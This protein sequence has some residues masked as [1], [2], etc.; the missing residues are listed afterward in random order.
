MHWRFSFTRMSPWNKETDSMTLK[1]LTVTTLGS[2]LK[3][4]LNNVLFT[5]RRVPML[6]SQDIFKPTKSWILF[7]LKTAIPCNSQQV[8]DNVIH[9]WCVGLMP[10][11]DSY[12][13]DSCHSMPHTRVHTTNPYWVT[14]NS[15]SLTRISSF[16]S[17][18]LASHIFL[19]SCS[20]ALLVILSGASLVSHFSHHT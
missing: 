3:Q 4:I 19:F 16:R 11:C 9:T 15:Y 17:F 10:Q 20:M 6:I 18:R 13:S 8:S 5:S 1:W 7:N 2:C 12:H 14:N